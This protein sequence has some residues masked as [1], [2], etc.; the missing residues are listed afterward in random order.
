MPEARLAYNPPQDELPGDQDSQH[1]QEQPQVPCRSDALKLLR[2]VESWGEMTGTVSPLDQRPGL[3]TGEQLSLF[4]I[5]AMSEEALGASARRM[6]QELICFPPKPAT[7]SEQ[8]AL[9]SS[10]E[11]SGALDELLDAG[12]VETAGPNRY[13]MHRSIV[14]YGESRAHDSSIRRRFVQEVAAHV[15][16][17]I[18]QPQKLEPD[19]PLVQRAPE[20]AEQDGLVADWVQIAQHYYQYLS[21]AGLYRQAIPM[22][23]AAVAAAAQEQRASDLLTLSNDLGAAYQHIGDYSAA[24]ERYERAHALDGELQQE[25]AICAALQGLGA[26]EFSRGNFGSAEDAYR[27]GLKLAVKAGLPERRA[28]FLSNLG[29]LAVSQANPAK[30]KELFAEGLT[31]A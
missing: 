6:L 20:F 12:L 7:F 24:R 9:A 16:D 13:R 3:E 31:L 29:I 10:G 8:L 18:C 14:R 21:R 1:S 2:D 28:G 11:P 22:I 17:L 4:K 25:D 5:I 27:E 15:R 30:A 26:V 19:V 23:E